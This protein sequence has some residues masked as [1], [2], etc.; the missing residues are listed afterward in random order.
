M[1]DK[2]LG[3]KKQGNLTKLTI[4]NVVLKRSKQTSRQI[5]P[6]GHRCRGLVFRVV[7]EKIAYSGAR[8]P[9]LKSN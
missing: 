5:Q 3:L 1:F 4:Q 8:G 2:I 7:A 9:R 6:I